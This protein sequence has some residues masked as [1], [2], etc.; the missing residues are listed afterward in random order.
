MA[1][2]YGDRDRARGR[3][4]TVAWLAEELGELAR[5]VRKGTPEEQLHELGDVL[6]WL[7]SLADQLGLSLDEAAAHY[8][9][10]C[11]RCGGSP[12]TCD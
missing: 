4:A 3:E 11:P 5:A 7:A 6:A 10:G 2:T 8:A 12:C 9:T 1:R